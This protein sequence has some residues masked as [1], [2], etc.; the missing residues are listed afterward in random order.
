MEGVHI[1]LTSGEESRIARRHT[2]NAQAFELY[3]ARVSCPGP[4]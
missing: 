4:L 2:G 1:A 3:L